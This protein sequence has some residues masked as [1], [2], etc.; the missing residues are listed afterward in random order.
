MD[1]LN[2]VPDHDRSRPDTSQ[3]RRLGTSSESSAGVSM[4]VKRQNKKTRPITE[5]QSPNTTNHIDDRVEMLIAQGARALLLRDES[6]PSHFALHVVLFPESPRSRPWSLVSRIRCPFKSALGYE[7]VSG[8]FVQPFLETRPP[9]R[10]LF[11]VGKRLARVEGVGGAG[12]RRQA[13]SW[14]ISSRR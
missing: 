1:I 3:G 14:R 9:I 11:A 5:H 8:S 4:S 10:R 2:A 6:F 13:H 7:V 12:G